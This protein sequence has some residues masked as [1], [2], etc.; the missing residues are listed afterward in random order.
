VFLAL[1]L[2]EKTLFYFGV[3]HSVARTLS[4]LLEEPSIATTLQGILYIFAATCFGPC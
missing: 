2:E 4:R 1:S 3:L